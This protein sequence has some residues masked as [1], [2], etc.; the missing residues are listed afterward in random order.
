MN[1]EIMYSKNHLWVLIENGIATIGLSEYARRQLG[2][3]AFLN[4]PEIDEVY[5][6]ND[7]FGDVESIKTVSDLISPVN[8]KVVEINSDMADM[9]ENINDDITESWL[10]K[11]QL[12]DDLYE[13]MDAVAYQNYVEQL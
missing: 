4:L 9:P 2:T 8:G 12:S 6:Q 13:L 3:I 10:V 5:G 11:F 1:K 7:I